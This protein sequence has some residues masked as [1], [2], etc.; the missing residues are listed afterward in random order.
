MAVLGRDVMNMFSDSSQYKTPGEFFRIT[1][2]D[3]ER[4]RQL[5]GRK[6]AHI[7]RGIGIVTDLVLVTR[8]MGHDK[9]CDG[10]FVNFA[11]GQVRLKPESFRD[12]T[13]VG[14][15]IE[16]EAHTQA[17]LALIQKAFESDFLNTDRIV[18]A[19]PDAELIDGDEYARLK[20][21][22]V[23][24]W[25]HDRQ[26]ELDQEQAA[27]VAA[28]E[29]DTL[30]VA[31]AGSGK[32]Q[33]LITRAI[34]LL[35]HCRVRPKELLLL[36]FN[37][38]AAAEMRT[39]IA[40]VIEGALPHVMTFHA[41]A[42][43]LVHP[44]EELVFDDVSADQLGLSR[45]VQEVIDEHIRS[46]DH[47][48]RIRDLMLGHFRD[49]WERIVGGRFEQTM[50]EFLAH[51]RALPRE[52]LK[53]DYVKSFG[54]K[55]IANTLF[56]YGVEYHY[57][58]N[59]RWGDVNYRPD[60]TIPFASTGRRGVIIE[61]FGLQSDTD[62]DE[63]SKKK[64]AFWTKRQEWTFLE[65]S[66]VDL[67]RNGTEAFVEN[68]VE[69]LRSIGVPCQRLSEEDIWEL[70]KK[71]AIDS[72][73]AAMKTFVGRCRKLN[74]SP[75]KLSQM[76]KEHRT[77]STT[78]ELFLDV[79]ISIYT[80][81]L[82]RLRKNN[83]EDF[84]G[85]MW[86]AVAL[87]QGGQTHFVR[88][89]GRERGDLK[90]LRFVM[91]DEFQDFSQM[92]YDLIEAI[93]SKNPH[94]QFFCVGDDWQAINAFAG[95]D[96]C[97]FE[98]FTRYFQTTSKYY[99][100]TNYRSPKNVV[101]A[102]NALMHGLGENAQ[103][104]STDHGLILLCN[105]DTF[106]P[107]TI[108]QEKH[109]GDEITPALLRVARKLLD[110]GL[111]VVM[112]SRR[113]GVPWYV[114][115]NATL[116]RIPDVLLRFLEHIRS[117]LPEEDRGRVTASTVHQYKGLERS[118]VVVLDAID[119]S[120]PL[121]HPNWV[122]LRVFGET[123]D[124]IEA[125]ERRLFYVAVTRAQNSLAL[126]TERATRSPYVGDIDHRMSLH[127]LEWKEFPPVCSLDAPRLEIR[128]FNAYHVRDQL[129][130]LKYSWDNT[131]KCWHRTVM[132]EGFLFD[133][134]LQQPWAQEGVK[135]EVYSEAGRLLQQRVP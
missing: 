132:A 117:H 18:R 58:R 120:Y 54:E 42:Y 66:P 3:P 95:S 65:F 17:G 33:T 49:D 43:A 19:A 124:R 35:K 34:F 6:I 61:Y 67:L 73:T 31:R 64:R 106:L 36:A 51:R 25:A 107:S 63:M 2:T 87:V 91:I 99:I 59:Y 135:I 52:S 103:A 53:G 82:E 97:F 20:A 14:I 29:G 104:H 109:N 108:E 111:D 74:W 60:F 98:D 93:R 24:R 47:R 48:E 62:Y 96:L 85:L 23:Q 21:Q 27:A 1:L 46:K 71:R 115:Y 69:K 81:Y 28:T 77:G 86:R 10:I 44:D 89:K 119:R 128:V 123:V 41:L 26:L 37:K 16:S 12:G 55:L 118:A 75:D 45:D 70:V 113:N 126:L 57:E 130:D 122:F 76:V 92:F 32:T 90:N 56:E 114:N 39:R 129:K 72:F 50:D 94:V 105:L 116:A 11:D 83:T 100:R 88:D 127:Q 84:D 68:L 22:F 110:R 7:E 38:K 80:G 125:E 78:E 102:G 79:G 9:Y 15:S 13:V 121:I 101:E 4:W 5:R 30:V 133:D 134:L 112:L 131:A 8:N 40:K